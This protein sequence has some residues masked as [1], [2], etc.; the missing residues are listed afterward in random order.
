MPQASK[1][2]SDLFPGGCEEAMAVLEGAGY[3]YTRCWS[4]I[5]PK[6]HKPS[7]RE[8]DAIDY[9]FAEWD[10]AGLTSAED[11]IDEYGQD[12]DCE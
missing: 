12:C 9:L 8:I 4:W 6:N 3:K 1:E 11:D 2:S 5:C 10:W 7:E